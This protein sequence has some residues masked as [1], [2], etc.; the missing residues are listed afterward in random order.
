MTQRYYWTRRLSLPGTV[1]LFPE[2]PKNALLNWTL[3]CGQQKSRGGR[4]PVDSI[5]KNQLFYE[6]LHCGPGSLFCPANY[7]RFSNISMG[8][9]VYTVSRLSIVKGSYQSLAHSMV[10]SWVASL[11]QNRPWN[12]LHSF[13]VRRHAR[14]W[15]KTTPMR[16]KLYLKPLLFNC[17]YMFVWSRLEI[18]VCVW[19]KSSE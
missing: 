12:T 19:P 18:F 1:I 7:T 14:H 3:Q 5:D 8:M 2:K 11:L 15:E 16:L 17:A 9:L 10:T 4:Y 13:V 6:T